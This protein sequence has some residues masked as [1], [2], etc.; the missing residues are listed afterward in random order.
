MRSKLTIALVAIISVV[1]IQ[2]S[3]LT[4]SFFKG[5]GLPYSGPVSFKPKSTPL[6]DDPDLVIGTTF[7]Y[8]TTTNGFF[9]GT[10]KPGIYEMWTSSPDRHVYIDVPDD[11]DTYPLADRITNNVAYAGSGI[12]SSL[13]YTDDLAL[14]ANIAN[15][16]FT[17]AITT[18]RIV[19]SNNGATPA[20]PASGFVLWSTNNVLKAIGASGTIT[21]I[22][23]P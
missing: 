1:A 23:L 12:P 15:P 20:T 9:T 18:P 8:Q 22:A 16:T 6:L 10:F 4:N 13:E 11:T 2:A 5:N 14:K 3:T 21:S 19:I 7:V 17:T